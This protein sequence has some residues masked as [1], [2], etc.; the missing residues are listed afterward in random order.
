[1]K[2]LGFEPGVDT[3]VKPTPKEL[4]VKLTNLSP[5]QK[6]AFITSLSA[7]IGS[8]KADAAAIDELAELFRLPQWQ[9]CGSAGDFIQCASEILRQRRD[10]TTHATADTLDYYGYDETDYPSV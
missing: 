9:V 6:D 1:M 4:L 5:E 10:L 2:R 7:Q 3:K 8:M